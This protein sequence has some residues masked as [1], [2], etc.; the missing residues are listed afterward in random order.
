[1][2]Y[3]SSMCSVHIT[4]E[5]SPINIIGSVPQLMTTR[6]GFSNSHGYQDVYAH[7]QF[8]TFNIHVNNNTINGNNGMRALTER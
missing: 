8:T 2:F 4:C 6:D 7:K 3:N 1:M 5:H